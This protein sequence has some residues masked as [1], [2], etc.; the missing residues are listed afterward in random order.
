M[1]GLL[2][3]LFVVLVVL[4]CFLFEPDAVDSPLEGLASGMFCFEDGMKLSYFSMLRICLSFHFFSL[5][6]EGLRVSIYLMYLTK[7]LYLFFF[8]KFVEF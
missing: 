7:H 4:S 1:S 8:D 3:P 2:V 6:V 5:V